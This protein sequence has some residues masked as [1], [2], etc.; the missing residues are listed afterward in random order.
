[1]IEE[2][3]L[4]APIILIGLNFLWTVS[5]YR[6]G[7]RKDELD[8]LRDDVKGVKERLAQHVQDGSDSRQAIA[9]RLTTIEG[10]LKH[11]PDAHSAKRT[12]VALSEV[13]GE[14]QVLSERLKPVA[15]ISERLQEF[16][17]EEAKDR[18]SRG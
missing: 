14:L 9:A 15:A 6:A 11:L 5:V 2:L 8:E 18:R 17:L 4:W 3:R 7:A 10:D 16:L 1:M 13:R 12:E